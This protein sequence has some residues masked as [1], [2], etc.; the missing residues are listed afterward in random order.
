MKYTLTCEEGLR[1]V[2]T[3]QPERGGS[4][5]FN[6]VLEKPQPAHRY[7]KHSQTLENKSVKVHEVHTGNSLQQIL[8]VARSTDTWT[9]PTY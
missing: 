7:R 4:S 6:P 3:R 9:L 2:E 8:C 1:E 5:V